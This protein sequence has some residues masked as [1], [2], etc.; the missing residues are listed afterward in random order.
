MS[1]V[2]LSSPKANHQT[3]EDAW[4]QRADQ[5]GLAQLDSPVWNDLHDALHAVGSGYHQAVK[6]WIHLVEDRFLATWESYESGDVLDEEVSTES[7]LCHRFLMEGVELWLSALADFRDSVDDRV[8]RDSILKQAEAGQRF[9]V[10]VQLIN[11]EAESVTN[12]FLSW[13]RN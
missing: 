11:D 12:N 13:A 1:L 5:L 2:T 9:L 10:L 6:E 4:L 7:V 8:D 3:L